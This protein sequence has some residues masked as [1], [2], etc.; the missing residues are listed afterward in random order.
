MAKSSGWCVLVATDGSPEARAAVAATAAFPWPAGTRVAGVVA[1]RT[2]VTRG[3]PQYF[4]DA[5]DRVYQRAARAAERVLAKR[6]PDAKVTVVDA[7]PVDG[8]LDEA[9]RLGASAIATGTRTRGRL[10]RLLLGSVA[11]QVV[12]RASCPV[13]VVKG[14]GHEFARFVIGVDGSKGSRHAVELVARLPPPRGGRVTLV[15][16]VELMRPPSLTLV[17]A[18]VREVVLSEATAENARRRAEGE[19]HVAAAAR[20]LERAG[21]T[22]RRTVRE[23]HPLADLLAATEESEAQVLVVG[24]RG[25]GGMERLL[26]GSVAE[27]ALTRS[28]VPVLVVR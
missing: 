2:L 4:V 16:V 14:R 1:R 28:P 3:R 21:W 26:L 24:A 15:A 13:L 12:R 25:I 10:P 22:A 27:G 5:F 19:R 7:T 23:G 18:A 20:V 9:R 17:P 6:W 8:I 11:R